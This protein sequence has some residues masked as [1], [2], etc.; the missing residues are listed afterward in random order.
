[1]PAIGL[2]LDG[3]VA[4]LRQDVLRARL[5]V[6]TERVVAA[7]RHL[8]AEGIVERTSTGWILSS[9]STT[10]SG[11]AETKGGDTPVEE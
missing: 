11:E 3:G 10:K 6:R 8:E 5:E 9:S 1:M 4:P 7:L 2:F